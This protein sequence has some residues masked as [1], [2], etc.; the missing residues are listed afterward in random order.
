[1]TL[2]LEQ[3]AALTDEDWGGANPLSPVFRADPYP[4]LARLRERDPVNLTPLGIRRVTRLAEVSYTLKNAPTR[5]TLGDG[6]SPNFDPLDR[7]GDFHDF[8][9]NKDG[10]EHLR[11]HRPVIK[12]FTG[13]AVARMEGRS[14]LG[15][16]C[17][18]AATPRLDVDGMAWSNSFFSVFGRVPV[19]VH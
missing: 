19:S 16:F 2:T 17:R 4:A 15:E 11:L 18:R 9:L 7:R 1:M 10:E 14:A 6:S 12:A 8:M 3:M 13:R 5:Q